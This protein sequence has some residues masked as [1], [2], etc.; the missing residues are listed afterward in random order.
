MSAIETGWRFAT[1][2]GSAFDLS[3]ASGSSTVSATEFA[4]VFDWRF[5]IG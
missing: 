5:E 2:L 3:F 1:D 4:S